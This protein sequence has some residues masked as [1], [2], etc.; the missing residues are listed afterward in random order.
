MSIYS[1]IFLGG[2]H[3]TRKH[4]VGSLEIKSEVSGD[5][6]DIGEVNDVVHLSPVQVLV[7]V[8]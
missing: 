6:G 8:Q 5:D 3:C 7:D 2:Y 4:N 1:R